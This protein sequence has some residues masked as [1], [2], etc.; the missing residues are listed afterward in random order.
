MS[1]EKHVVVVGYDGSPAS[2]AAVVHA[3]G[4]AGRSGCVYVVHSYRVPADYWGTGYY[5]EMLDH[6]ARE[7]HELMER[8][9]HDIEVLA[10]VEW[11]PEIVGAIPAKAI[12]DVAA[13]R[14]A[15]EIVVGSR[16]YGRARALLGSVSHELIHLAHC[17][18]TVIPERAVEAVPTPA[19]AEA[20]AA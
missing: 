15:D 7:G 19:A 10:D 13:T 4:R 5:Q 11:Y 12:A 8:L 16:G 2:R 3:V 14:Q 1:H 9:P 20:T 18:V 17:P 6:V